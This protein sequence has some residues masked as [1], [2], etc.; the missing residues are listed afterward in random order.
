MGPT[1]YAIRFRKPPTL[2]E[3][4]ARRDTAT[5]EFVQ[6]LKTTVQPACIILFGSVAR[7]V[8]TVTSDLDFVVIGGQLPQRMFDRLDVLAKLKRD[9]R[10]SID[11]FPYTEAEFE[12]MLDHTN[13]LALES[14]HEGRPLHGEVYFNRLRAKFDTLARRGLRRVKY[15]WDTRLKSP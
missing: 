10:S 12:Q 14:M 5:R 9:I 15:G 4:R 2:E 1:T 3:Q 7:G 13:L 6:R 8:D 11:A